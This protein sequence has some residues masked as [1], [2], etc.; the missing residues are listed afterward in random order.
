MG[1]KKMCGILCILGATVAYALVP[2]FSFLAFGVGV[3]TETV[4]FN[5]FF[6]ASILIWAYIFFKKIPFRVSKEA[7]PVLAAI[8]I[9]YI[10]LAT[11]L[12]L[13][14]DYISGSLATIISFIFPA[15]VLAVEMIRGTEPVRLLKIFA[16]LLAIVGLGF[17]VWNPDM[18]VHFLGVLFALLC[19]V[20]YAVYTLCLASKKLA[21]FHSIATAGYVLLGSTVFNFFRCMISGKPF[22]A[23]APEQLGCMLMLS[24]ICAFSAILLFCIGVKIIGAS[25]ASIIN[26]FEPVFACVFGFLFVGDEITLG[27]VIGG[28]LVVTAVLIANM[29]DRKKLPPQSK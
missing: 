15:F 23:L 10:G 5:K 25:N 3:E 1:N 22:L 21:D 4:L 2:S 14:Y 13:A 28:I 16:I 11:T 7:F 17:T 27:M 8:V 19:A 9:S 20:C 18:Q 6:Y 24:V 12:Y 26:T 29:P